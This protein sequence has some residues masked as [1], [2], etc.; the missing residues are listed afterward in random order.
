[1]KTKDFTY[2]IGD[3]EKKFTIKTPS[4]SDQKEASKIYN[5]AFSDAIK[6]KAL[7]RAK[8]DDVLVEQGLWDD[9]KQSKFNQLQN[10]ILNGERTLAKGGISLTE[11][12]NIAIDMRKARL[13]L[14]DLISVKTN[15][16]TH[17]A[18]GQADNA[19]FNY[20]VS[21]CLVYTDTKQPYF[22]G[23]EDYLNKAADP[24]AVLAAQH[25]ASMLYGLD[26]DYEEKLPE[27]KFLTKY[28]FIDNKLRLIN[29][30][31]KLVDEEG[32]LIDERG[33]FIN[34]KGEY[35]DKNGNPVTETGEYNF[36]FQP[37]LDD[38]GKPIQ[39]ETPKTEP[40]P[41]EVTAPDEP[42][43]E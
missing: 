43:Q 40:V 8:L 5:T 30:E 15:L 37:F 12:K 19:R 34:E 35:V 16:D 17:T 1:M 14:R 29:K 13:E 9:I 23:Y 21:C 31:G 32:R 11:A 36:E 38:E 24:L 28:K 33:R 41:Q 42:V 22:A 2:K 39:E 10:A 20:L 25:L 7:V 18:E 6:N 26:N 3:T 27:N 4:V